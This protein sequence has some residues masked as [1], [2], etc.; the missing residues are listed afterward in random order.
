MHERAL[1]LFASAILATFAPTGRS[2]DPPPELGDPP[3][4]AEPPGS[5]PQEKPAARSGTA[6]LED[7]AFLGLRTRPRRPDATS[8]GPIVTYV[9][10]GSSAD[11]L[12][13]RVGD[14]ILLLNDLVVPDQETL[15]RE[16]RR[17][18]IGSLVRFQVR[19]EGEEKRLSGKIGSHAES[20]RRYEDYLRKSFAGQLLP[21]PPEMVWWNR[22]TG[23]WE[24]RPDAW[25]D[26]RGKVTVVVS[27]DD[28]S[29]CRESRFGMLARL[30]TVMVAASR[31]APLG[32]A[33]IYYDERPG[34]SG[35]E[36]SLRSAAEL[37]R[38]ADPAFPVGVAYW[39]D[40]DLVPERT[41]E[42]F[43][44]LQH[45]VAILDSEGRIAYLQ[46]LG[47]PGAEFLAAYE[48]ALKG[49]APKAEEAPKEE[50]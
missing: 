30:R 31:K 49:I 16:L 17:L 26:F 6:A 5:A 33:G 29:L 35:K 22:E 23:V 34:K 15:V 8:G 21:E 28:C 19:R 13:F 1:A 3:R 42:Q 39:P 10:P 40:G 32:F 9:Y 20:L 46:V 2:E 50:K 41:D 48:K 24:E 43:L 36:A 47:V 44:I 14:E 27:F 38:S 12:G 4:G 25:K 11:A 37:Y 18:K 45:G 7:F